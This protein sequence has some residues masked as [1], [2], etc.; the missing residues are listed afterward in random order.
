M[1]STDITNLIYFGKN[2]KK[3]S[4]KAVILA[5]LA[6]LALDTIIGIVIMVA[7]ISSVLDHKISPEENTAIMNALMQRIDYLLV[8]LFFGLLTTIFAGYLA[9]RIAKNEPY[10]NSLAVGVIGIILGLFL[11]SSLPIW[12]NIISFVTIL[13]LSIYGGHLGRIRNDII[14]IKK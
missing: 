12:Y 2:M 5:T 8:C 1:R 7:F 14:N 11:I 6:G 9:A 10:L 4:F 13:P 3:I